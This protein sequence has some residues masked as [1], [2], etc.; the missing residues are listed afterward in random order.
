[1]PLVVGDEHWHLC[2]GVYVID[3]RAAGIYGRMATQ[4]LINHTARDVAVP[5]RGRFLL[6]S[7][8]KTIMAVAALLNDKPKPTDADIDR[9]ITNIC[10]CG[11]FQ[12]VREA[13]HAAAKA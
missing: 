9:T 6:Y 2:F 10:R 3:G 8:T 11:T 7:I 12:Q 1:M 13:I 5:S 4:P